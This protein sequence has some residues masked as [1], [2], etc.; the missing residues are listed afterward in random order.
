MAGCRRQMTTVLL[1]RRST[2]KHA[3]GSGVEQRKLWSSTVPGTSPN[4]NS[5]LLS[6]SS[7][8]FF[9]CCFLSLLL[10]SGFLF[11]FSCWGF[12]VPERVF[13]FSFF[14]FSVGFG[15]WPGDGEGLFGDFG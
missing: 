14:L 3:T 13:F 5:P 9:L 7:F 4:S 15:I 2:G 11:F 10:L 6:S 12:G 1:L 8:S